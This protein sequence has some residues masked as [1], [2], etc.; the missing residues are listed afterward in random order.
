MVIILTDCN[1]TEVLAICSVQA[2]LSPQLSQYAKISNC[3]I[4]ASKFSMLSVI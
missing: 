3:I 4:L 1:L 2:I